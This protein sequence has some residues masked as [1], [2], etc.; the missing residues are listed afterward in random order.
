MDNVE[1]RFSLV[2]DSDIGKELCNFRNNKS[3]NT[4]IVEKILH[5]YKNYPIFTTSA[6]M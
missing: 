1:F 2:I 5:Y 4:H 6:L 3:C